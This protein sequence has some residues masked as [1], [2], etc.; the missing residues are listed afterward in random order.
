M[1]MWH[2]TIETE[3]EINMKTNEMFLMIFSKLNDSMTLWSELQ[4]SANWER[5]PSEKVKQQNQEI[6]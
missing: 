3:K 6:I 5:E 1:I 2:F 4:F